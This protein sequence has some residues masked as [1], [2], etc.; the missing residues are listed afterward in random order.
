MTIRKL[1]EVLADLKHALSGESI[2]MDALLD[3]LHERGFGVVLL[4][5]ALPL[6]IPIPKPPGIST[7]FGIPLFILTIQQALGRR[8]FWMPQFIRRRTVQKENLDKLLD[9]TIPAVQKIEVLIRPRLE[10]VTH[11]RFSRLI[12]ILGAIMAAFISIP[13]PGSNTIPG[14]GIALMAMGVMMRDGLAVI[15]GALVGTGWVFGLGSLY[16][17][18]GREGLNVLQSF[19]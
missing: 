6:S 9:H 4:V 8:V 11:G 10:W 7:L 14:I 12:G 2:T 17:F 15:I 5:F 1:S 19:L 16:L 13:L 18:F 3:G